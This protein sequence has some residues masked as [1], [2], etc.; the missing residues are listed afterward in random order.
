MIFFCINTGNNQID[1]NK[2]RILNYQNNQRCKNDHHNMIL[3]NFFNLQ[4]NYIRKFPLHDDVLT[5][6]F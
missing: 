2:I 6:E 4:S 1:I 5:K 3:D